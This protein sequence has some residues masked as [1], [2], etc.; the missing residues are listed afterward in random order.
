MSAGIASLPMYD[1]PELRSA[2]D[3]WWRAL[4]R[5]LRRAG[6]DEAPDDLARGVPRERAW[7]SPQLILTQTCGYPLRH[8][9]AGVLRRQRRTVAQSTIQAQHERLANVRGAFVPHPVDLTGWTVWLV[10]DVKTTGATAR[11]CCR[12]LRAGGAERVNLVVLAVAEPQTGDMR[13]T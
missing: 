2:T 9:F 13:Q 11:E 7:R 4:A 3:D 12:L 10:D 8:R 1:L 5:A 6:I